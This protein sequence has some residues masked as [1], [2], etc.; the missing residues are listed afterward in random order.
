M[1]AFTKSSGSHSCKHYTLPACV[2][3]A[4]ALSHWVSRLVEFMSRSAV[5]DTFSLISLMADLPFYSLIK[6]CI[7]HHKIHP[8]KG[9]KFGGFYYL[10]ADPDQHRAEDERYMFFATSWSSPLTQFS[11][12]L[13]LTRAVFSPLGAGKA[14]E[15]APWGCRLDS[16]CHDP[17]SPKGNKLNSE[18]LIL[19]KTKEKG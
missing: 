11:W 13:C 10:Q 12:A 9:V 17:K 19:L 14:W 1:M 8:L 16:A 2:H 5:S 4:L 15:G 3:R 18:C 7:T 6:V